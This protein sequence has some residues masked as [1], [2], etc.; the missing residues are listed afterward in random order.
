[1]K[2]IESSKIGLLMIENSLKVIIVEDEPLFRDLLTKALAAHARISVAGSYSDGKSALADAGRLN[3]SVAILDIELPTMNGIQIGLKLR[4]TF[5]NIGI[6]LL[7]NHGD[8]QYLSSVPPN[9]RSGWSYL[10]KKSVNDVEALVRAIE[11]AADGFIVLDKQLVND[12]KVKTDSKLASLSK[13]QRD[14]LDLMAQGYNNSAI[15]Q[16]LVI[17]EKT[18]ENQVSM[19]YQQLGIS[20]VHPDWHPRTKA[21]LMYLQENQAKRP[22]EA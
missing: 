18:V 10:L 22:A 6:V 17:S 14:F 11:G 12:V 4:Q 2:Q 16:K 21:V 7:S 1:M 20:S 8:L 9:S 3:P 15:A 5:P 19:L 13:R